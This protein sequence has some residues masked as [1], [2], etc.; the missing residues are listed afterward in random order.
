MDVLSDVLKAIRLTGSVFFVADLYEP[1]SISSPSLEMLQHHMGKKVECIS[2]FHIVTEGSCTFKT[3]KGNPFVV[4]QGSL[5][6][7]PNSH[8]H[9]M[10]STLDCNPVPVVRLLTPEALEGKSPLRHGGTGKKAQFICGYLLCDQRFNP[11]L[12]ALPEVMVLSA[13]AK[14]NSAQIWPREVFH[15]EVDGWLYASLN[16]LVKEVLERKSGS[17]TIIT[18]LT[19]VMYIEALRQYMNALPENSG[20]WLA[21]VRD[22]EIGRALRL[23]HANPGKKWSVEQLADEV[24]VSRSAFARRFTELIGESPMHYLTTWRMQLAKSLL[25]D[26]QLGLALVAEKI[27][28]DSD[29][30]F[31]R[32]F[33]RHVGMPPAR[34]K[35]SNERMGE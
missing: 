29:V 33:Q 35:K 13:D 16:Q 31:N 32:A 26:H 12:G 3:E 21:A 14:G 10:G 15:F 30:A 6:I 25:A 27:G 9:V 5:I 19:E 34:W 11:L 2:L 20:G 23:L 17:T 1:W 7:F 18:R 22:P 4:Q 24:G 8:E 28:Y